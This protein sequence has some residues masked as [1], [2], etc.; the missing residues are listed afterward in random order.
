MCGT[1]STPS[2]KKLPV[3]HIVPASLGG[4]HELDNLVTLCPPCHVR[5]DK[6]ML[7]ETLKALQW[8]P[9]KIDGL[10]KSILERLKAGSCS[11]R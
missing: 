10:T 4:S 6:S 3:H 11:R 9:E 5:L 7:E 1:T 2:G 8:E